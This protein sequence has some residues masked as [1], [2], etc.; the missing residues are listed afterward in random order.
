MGIK[1]LAAPVVA[2]A[3]AF[4][5]AA[6]TAGPAAAINNIKPFGVQEKLQGFGSGEVGYTVDRIAPSSVLVNNGTEDLLA[7]V[8]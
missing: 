1:K 6:A 3:L 4:G 7:W 2:A 8:G 5:I